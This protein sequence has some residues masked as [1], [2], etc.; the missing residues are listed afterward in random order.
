ME[1]GDAIAAPRSTHEQLVEMG[2]DLSCLTKDAR[3]A[4][5]NFLEVIEN[6]KN[7]GWKPSF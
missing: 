6:D 5:R 4:L 7:S 2:I 3:A 1:S